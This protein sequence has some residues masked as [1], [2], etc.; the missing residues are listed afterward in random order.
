VKTPFLKHP[1]YKWILIMLLLAALMVVVFIYYNRRI[2]ILN[3]ELQRIS[4]MSQTYE[5]FKTS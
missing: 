4:M 2:K 3:D 5:V 1:G